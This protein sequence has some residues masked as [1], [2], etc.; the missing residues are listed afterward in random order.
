MSMQ[1]KVILITG[2]ARGIGAETARR[3]AKRGARLS[4]VGMEPDQLE[5][6][7]RQLGPAH[8]W[9]ECDVT[10][11]SDLDRAVRATID[12]MG[13][14]DVV[15]ANAGIATHGTVRVTS[16]DALTR[17]IDVNLIGV[18]RTVHATLPSLIESRGYYLLVSSAA[19]FTALP[20]MAAYA[21]SKAG[22]EQFGNVLRLEVSHTGVQVGLAHMTWIDTDM[23]RDIR[24]DMKSFDR[25]LRQLP[26]V[27]G[28][29]TTVEHCADAFVDAIENRTRRV[30]VPA[31]L[32]RMSAL[33]AIIN[34]AWL[35]RKNLQRAG[36]MVQV[37][38]AE[39]LRQPRTFGEHSVGMGK[40]K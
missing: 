32:S 23:V 35:E 26:G 16:I 12:E 19:A 4:L 9:Y 24:H 7:A 6:L 34:S 36:A 2:A 1:D 25:A 39:A 30:F 14:I 10:S 28:K 8:R 5:S 11:Q 29:V 21:A 3:L 13:R 15:V 27:F 31:A 18:M 37:A 33:R 38:E 20:G 40:V 17:V 22:V